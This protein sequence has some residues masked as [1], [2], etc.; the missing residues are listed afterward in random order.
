MSNGEPQAATPSRHERFRQIMETAAGTAQADYQGHG[1]FW[2]LPLAELRD[3]KLY[4]IMMMRP[5]GGASSAPAPAPADTSCCHAPASPAPAGGGGNGDTAGLA[6]GLRGQYPFDGT[7]FPPLPW[8]GARVPETD[9]R[10]IAQWIGAGCPAADEEAKSLTH[11]MS[12]S[13]RTALALGHAPHVAFTGPTNLLAEEAGRV[14]TRKDVEHMPP[15]DL[16]RLRKAIA[17]MKSL[18]AYYQDERS[19]AFWGRVHA[20][21]CQHGWEEFLTW[22]RVYLYFF[23]KQLQDIDRT[24]TLPYWNWAA[25]TQNVQA[26]MQDMGNATNDNGYVPPAYQC[27]ID[28]DGLRKLTDG[29]K[30]P[31]PVLN[32]L[33]GKLEQPFSSG[34]RLFKAAGINFG[35]DPASD[36][37]II[38]VLGEINPLWHWR[39]WPGGNKSLIFEAYPSQANVDNIL[40]IPNFFAFGSGPM[41]HQ[42]FGAL[43]NIH[44]LLHN[45]SGGASPYP[46]GPNNEFSTGDMVDPGRTAFDPIFWGH[47]S[48]VDR[49]WAEWQRTNPGRGPDNPDAV[50][51]PWN[52]TVADT[53]SISALGY[54]YAKATHVFPTES[55]MPLQRFRSADTPIHPKVLSDHSRAEIRMQAIQ[56]VPRPGFYVRAFF[57][58]PDASVD[59]PTRGNPNYVGQM[60]MFTGLCIGGPGHCDVPSGPNDRFDLRPRH[61]KT[62]SSFHFDATDSVRALAEQG[63]TALQVNLVALNLDGSPAGDALKLDA[64]KLM[65]FD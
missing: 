4:G 5:A 57:N 41:D 56:Y 51:P 54:E 63:V 64:V 53:Y 46:V 37:A 11:V 8:G 23:E 36:A 44:N 17:Q 65:F 61:H 16:K 28:E 25:D 32:G 24:V 62:P 31:G 29:G 55:G 14:K 13:E 27:W 3:L 7:Q 50:L 2:N 59:T 48:N 42:F 10:F 60:N 39:R 18:D 19:F 6:R 20:N 35:E 15:D 43:E 22:H 1:R 49:L 9:I 45:F 47:H 38:A 34:A 58:T 40:K 52:F 26:S 30:V 33:R 21:Q 12:G